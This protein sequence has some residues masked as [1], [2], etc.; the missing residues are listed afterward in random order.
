[1]NKI[2]NAY[3]SVHERSLADELIRDILDQRQYLNGL[4]GSK[5]GPTCIKKKLFFIKM[6]IDIISENT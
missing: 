1:M 6:N 3:I 2:L 5:R 4:K